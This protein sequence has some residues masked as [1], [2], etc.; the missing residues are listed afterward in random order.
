M[1]PVPFFALLKD[2]EV[3]E[4][5]YPFYARL[6]D[7]GRVLPN[8]L[9][10]WV[11][12]HHAECAL[13]LR[14]NRF[15]ANSKHQNN[16]E[17]FAQLAEAVGLS[18]L[19][20]LFGRLILFADPPD[21]TRLRR[22][23]SKAFTVR[24]VEEMRPRIA[25]IVDGMLD[26]VADG[27]SMELVETLAFPLPVTVISDMLG[28]PAADHDLLRGWTSEAVK[29]LDPIDDPM[30]LFPA[31]EALRAMQAYF[32]ELVTE[33]RRHLG[34]DLLSAFIQA[35]DDGDRL[36]H[37]EL[38]ET[39]ILLFGAG[40]ETTVNLITGGA[41]NLLRHPDQLQ[42]LRDDPSLMAS[43]TE[44]LLRF[45]PPVQ[46]TGR[47]AT[48]DIELSDQ[49]IKKGTE[50]IL[51]LASANRDPAVFDDPDALDVGRRHNHHLSFSGGIHFCLG[52]PLARI[53]A[54]EALGRLL[55][56]FPDLALPE[57]EVDWKPTTTIRGPKE[58]H[59]T[60]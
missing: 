55:T 6:R 4:D 38:L 25:N 31:G 7:T 34:P 44:E 5:P 23:A 57:P 30:V 2:P 33:R 49:L 46:L 35:E 59:L 8:D 40:H 54:Q 45:G 15:S 20:E 42:R 14:D 41:Y 36:S 27:D 60:W 21:H 12:P 13:V 24:A 50:V 3:H 58:L 32:D 28:V 39:T 10:G 52:A 9:G 22:I 51:M 56:R 47:I 43:A 26:K 11:A 37:Q 29:A 1:E 19:L 17:Q 48:E 18:D 16:F 53:E